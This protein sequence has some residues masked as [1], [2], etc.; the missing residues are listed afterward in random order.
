VVACGLDGVQMT[1]V[2]KETGGGE[3]P[4]FDDVR[5]SAARRFAE[6]F[7]RDAVDVDPAALEG[8][9]APAGRRGSGA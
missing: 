8:A 1:S 6:A 5:A 4:A 3:T 7:G 2:I 9:I